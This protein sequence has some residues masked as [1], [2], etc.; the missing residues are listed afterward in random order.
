M[1]EQSVKQNVW[2]EFIVER[3]DQVDRT[4]TSP[5]WKK[6]IHPWLQAQRE[7]F[8]RDVLSGKD[9]MTIDVSRG[10]VMAFEQI[11]NLGKAI[12]Y[13]RNRK[14]TEDQKYDN[15]KSGSLDTDSNITDWQD[16]L[17]GFPIID[18]EVH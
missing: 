13:E 2:N 15:M 10:Y 17:M 14:S 4:L 8:L 9:H 3:I 11:M 18:E 6:A 12:E 5:G 16:S 1:K 7:I